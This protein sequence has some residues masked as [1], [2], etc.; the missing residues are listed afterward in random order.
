[1]RLA[2]LHTVLFIT[3][4]VA[5]CSPTPTP[6]PVDEM[7]P[8]Y[9]A[10]KRI[11]AAIGIG[12]TKLRFAD[13]RMDLATEVLL[14]TDEVTHNSTKVQ[15]LKRHLEA[16]TRLLEVYNLSAEVW[17]IRSEFESCVDRVGEK[18]CRNQY[19]SDFGNLRKK[20]G[21]ADIPVDLSS[22]AAVTLAW[23]SI[24]TIHDRADEALLLAGVG[25]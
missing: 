25:P 1:M 6:T 5:G 2:A 9:E 22:G 16:Y 20:L 8:V 19:T 11:K 17:E 18:F 15:A 21:D 14:K 3:V 10:A 13:L 4:V 23:S 7:R 12:V 24:R